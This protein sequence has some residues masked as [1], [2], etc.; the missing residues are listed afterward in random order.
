MSASYAIENEVGP[1]RSRNQLCLAR[2][3][4]LASNPP[5]TSLPG[6]VAAEVAESVGTIVAQA[7]EARRAIVSVSGGGQQAV[8]CLPRRAAQAGQGGTG[9]CYGQVGPL[10]AAGIGE[11]EAG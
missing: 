3:A 1:S 5:G 6:G 4:V 11:R 2:L 7:T 10:D 9:P 8:G